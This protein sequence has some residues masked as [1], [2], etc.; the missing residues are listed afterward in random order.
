MFTLKNIFKPISMLVLFSVIWF[1]YSDSIVSRFTYSRLAVSPSFGLSRL[2]SPRAAG[3]VLVIPY[4]LDMESY[5][6][7]W[8]NHP[9]RF[10]GW[11]FQPLKT[12]KNNCSGFYAE[13]SQKRPKI[14]QFTQALENSSV[15]R[16]LG[17]NSQGFAQ[18][19]GISLG[20]L[21]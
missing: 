10:T 18:N 9:Q 1:C 12:P 4:L 21:S 2:V 15:F 5:S 13:N 14:Q 8:Q 17:R 3:T 19:L 7:G 20:R 6:Q 11:G 16:I